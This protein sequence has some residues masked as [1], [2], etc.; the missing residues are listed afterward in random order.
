MTATY[1]YWPEDK[2]P[3]SD[4]EVGNFWLKPL[5]FSLIL[6]IINV[7]KYYTLYIMFIKRD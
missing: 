7:P 1:I 3:Y 5:F 4:N 6:I 2:H